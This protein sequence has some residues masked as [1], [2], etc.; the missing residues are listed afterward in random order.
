MALR[1][2]QITI[3]CR[4]SGLRTSSCDNLRKAAAS[5]RAAEPSCIDCVVKALASGADISCGA[6]CASAGQQP[7]R[8]VLDGDFAAI[9]WVA[10][11]PLSELGYSPTAGVDYYIWALQISGL[12]T[13]LSG[14]NFV[15][16]ILRM[17]A[18]GMTL[19]K[20]PVFVWTALI[21]NILIVAVFPVLTATLALLL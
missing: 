3:P 15:V 1:L 2:S 9:G 17:R 10:Y 7:V 13:L 21:T 20:M 14:I 8:G 6:K 18:P 11:P 4:L 19:M 5:S 16:I 12:G